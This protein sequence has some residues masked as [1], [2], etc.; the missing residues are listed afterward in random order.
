MRVNPLL[1]VLPVILTLC[2]GVIASIVNHQYSYI[3]LSHLERAPLVLVI[4][5]YI[6]AFFTLYYIHLGFTW[7]CVFLW[8]CAYVGTMHPERL[9]RETMDVI[10]N[11]TNVLYKNGLEPT[12][13]SYL[14]A[15]HSTC[16]PE[17]KHRRW[18]PR[19]ENHRVDSRLQ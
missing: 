7:I 17:C 19:V 16:V 5:F 18:K 4:W 1:Y 2:V 11:R 15:I 3:R 14:C 8:A 12:P 6:G 10:M 9:A 13:P